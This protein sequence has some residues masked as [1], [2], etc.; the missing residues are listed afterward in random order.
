MPQERALQITF[1]DGKYGYSSFPYY[2]ALAHLSQLMAINPTER[3]F[4]VYANIGRVRM[5]MGNGSLVFGDDL[6]MHGVIRAEKFTG[7]PLD[8]TLATLNTGLKPVMEVNAGT[9]ECRVYYPARFQYAEPLL[10]RIYEVFKAD[11]WS[12]CREYLVDRYGATGLPVGNMEKATE[13]SKLFGRSFFIGH[14][15]EAGFEPVTTV[16]PGDMVV[17]GESGGVL[18]TGIYTENGELL[19]HMPG[20]LS[21]SEKYDGALVKFTQIILRHRS[22]MGK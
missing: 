20:R 15:L 5:V 11:C 7:Q 6:A 21:T 9:G 22:V 14:H 4:R 8:E 19:H 2:E 12:L 16:M 10:H 17:M 3:L 1:V 18:H 13:L